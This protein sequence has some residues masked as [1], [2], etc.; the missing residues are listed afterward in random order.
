MHREIVELMKNNPAAW[1]VALS[2][3][4]LK[5]YEN[6][7]N[8]V[9]IRIRPT[10]WMDKKVNAEILLK[11]ENFYKGLGVRDYFSEAKFTLGILKSL[12]KTNFSYIGHADFQGNT[13]FNGQPSSI[14][15]G[16]IKRN[17]NIEISKSSSAN[18]IPYSPLIETNPKLEMILADGYA[19]SN[20]PKGSFG[21]VNEFL[22][23]N[24]S[25]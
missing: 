12:Q 19:K 25:K 3:Q 5:D 2:S 20:L 16:L 7:M 17:G 13:K 11:L 15:W 21:S 4:L 23:L 6:L 14:Y 18:F 9:K 1:G 10:D 8:L 24:F 22:P